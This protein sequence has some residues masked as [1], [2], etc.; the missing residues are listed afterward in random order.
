MLTGW[1]VAKNPNRILAIK[2]AG[3]ETEKEFQP[4]P[5]GFLGRQKNREIVQS[6]NTDPGRVKQSGIRV[7]PTPQTSN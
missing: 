2:D 1:I 3:K 4:Q 5:F 7:I 6:Y